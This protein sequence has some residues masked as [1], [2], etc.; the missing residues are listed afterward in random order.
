MARELAMQRAGLPLPLDAQLERRR[1][2][3][4]FDNPI[5]NSGKDANG[6]TGRVD[7]DK[8][9]PKR[10]QGNKAA[11]T[12]SSEGLPADAHPS[13]RQLFWPLCFLPGHEWGLLVLAW[14]CIL[15]HVLHVKVDFVIRHS[16]A[17]SLVKC[18]LDSSSAAFSHLYSV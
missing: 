15:N 8:K 7:C 3:N 11:P 5:L 17:E 9:L 16:K 12:S 14:L 2:S 10:P 6:V 1:K 13:H 18:H 4:T